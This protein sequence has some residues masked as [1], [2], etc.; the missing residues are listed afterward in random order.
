MGQEPSEGSTSS[1]LLVFDCKC[2]CGV[3]HRATL[4]TS[5][6][7]DQTAMSGTVTHELTPLQL[8]VMQYVARGETD[9][10]IAGALRLTV[11]QVKRTIREILIRLE[12][13]NRA[14]A[15][16]EAIRIGANLDNAHTVS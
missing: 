7:L 10:A 5:W 3:R 14:Q 11:P 1:E 2:S 12:C 4:P 8:R 15:V 9:R 6:R 13:H 16:F